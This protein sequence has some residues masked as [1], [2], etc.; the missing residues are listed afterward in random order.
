MRA[1][2]LNGELTN[3]LVHPQDLKRLG[4]VS[5][6]TQ[7]T[8]KKLKVNPLDQGNNI[9]TLLI[10]SQP[11]SMGPSHSQSVSNLNP[12]PFQRKRSNQK[13]NSGVDQEESKLRKSMNRP[14]KTS[15]S[16]VTST[17]LTQSNPYN[18]ESKPEIR[19]TKT[20]RHSIEK[21]DQKPGVKKYN[22]PKAQLVTQNNAEAESDQEYHQLEITKSKRTLGLKSVNNFMH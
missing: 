16:K 3:V 15:K 14:L 6:P 17:F 13:E 12:S 9:G 7:G 10:G 5:Q 2:I 18:N 22:S 1:N 8:Q 19:K 21:V 11:S 4:L 20:S